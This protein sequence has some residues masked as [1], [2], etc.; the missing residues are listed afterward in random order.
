MVL[1][2]LVDHTSY[3]HGYNGI[4][5][6]RNEH[7]S[8]TDTHSHER[9]GPRKLKTNTKK[10]AFKVADKELMLEVLLKLSVVRD[11]FLKTLK[12]L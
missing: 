3:Y 12:L 10:V 6:G 9:K 2:V 4:I 7:Q 11:Y 1:N 5:P 8:Q